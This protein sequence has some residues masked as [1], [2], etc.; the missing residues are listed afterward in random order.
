MFDLFLDKKPS[1]FVGVDI[2]QDAIRALSLKQTSSGFELK[3][4]VIQPLPAGAV[5]NNEI[6][7]YD[8]VRK[9]LQEIRGAFKVTKVAVAMPG[10]SVISKVISLNRGLSERE[11]E[12]QAWQAASNIFPHKS[13]NMSLDFFVLP[14]DVAAANKI[15]VMLVAARTESV[16]LRCSVLADAGFKVRVVDIDQFALANACQYFLS[17]HDEI[18]LQSTTAVFDFR[19]RSLYLIILRNGVVVY[20]RETLLEDKEKELSFD[21]VKITE[22]P[23]EEADEKIELTEPSQKSTNEET[24]ELFDASNLTEQSTEDTTKSTAEEKADELFLDEVS[25]QPSVEKPA[26]ASSSTSKFSKIIMQMRRALQFFYSAS[27]SHD[28]DRVVLTGDIKNLRQDEF[29][30]QVKATMDL[31]V[32][33]ANPFQQV[34]MARSVDKQLLNENA[35]SMMISFGLALRGFDD[36]TH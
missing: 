13:E 25:S 28:L 5:T 11:I 14:E 8:V 21:E 9:A 1:V 17:K 6:S 16:D 23:K 26:A 34:T 31:E 33:F 20:T 24:T 7:D 32:I 27:E 12:E 18:S 15:D 35:S 30:Q 10:A 29:V 22:Q 36:V 19:Q 2:G 3:N 4:F